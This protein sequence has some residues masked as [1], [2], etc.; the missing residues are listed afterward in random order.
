MCERTRVFVAFDVCTSVELNVVPCPLPTM[1]G[2]AAPAVD[3]LFQSVDVWTVVAD[4]DKSGEVMVP[5]NLSH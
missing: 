3:D 2:S 5:N 4:G 1:R